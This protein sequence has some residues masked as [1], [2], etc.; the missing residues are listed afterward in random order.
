L[1][2]EIERDRTARTIAVAW[3]PDVEDFTRQRGRFLLY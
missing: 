3:Q 2:E 1:R